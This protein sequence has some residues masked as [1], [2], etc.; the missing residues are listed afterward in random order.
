MP[1]NRRETRRFHILPPFPCRAKKAAALLEQWMKDDVVRLLDVEFLPSSVDLKDPRYC[2]IHRKKGHM[3]EQC[4]TFRMIDEKHKYVK[5]YSKKE[6][7]ISTIFDM[8]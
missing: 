5:F 4:A 6:M 2:P 8:F 7:S 1:Y 3:L